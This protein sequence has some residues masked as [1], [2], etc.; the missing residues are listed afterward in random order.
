MTTKKQT[1]SMPDHIEEYF[2]QTEGS[3]QNIISRDLFKAEGSDIDLKTD[4]TNEEIT[5]LNTLFFN[6]EILR[7][8]GLKPVYSNWIE[9]F[10]RLKVS[11]DRLSRNEFVSLNRVQ[12][13][14]EEQ[15]NKLGSFSNILQSKK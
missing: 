6:N 12:E 4:L 15:L 13:P 1:K 9:K 14:A 11:K 5:I 3:K 8:R 2:I 10:M 7:K